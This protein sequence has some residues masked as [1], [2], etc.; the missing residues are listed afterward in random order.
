[1]NRAAVEFMAEHAG[2]ATPPGRM[3]CAWL[4]AE[5]ELVG[6]ALGWSVEWEEDPDPDLSWCER[7]ERR[8]KALRRDYSL[9]GSRRAAVL[10]GVLDHEH[11]LYVALLQDR[12][13]RVLGSLGGIDFGGGRPN[14]QQDPYR[15][16]VEAELAAEAV[17]Y[18]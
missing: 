13:G 2:Y 15:R 1:M 5:A 17:A 14:W 4:L 10:S 12:R 11:T 9:S 6:E 18:A 7:C 3:V 8:E 16:V